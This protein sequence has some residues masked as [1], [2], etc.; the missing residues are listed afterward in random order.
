M[1][2]DEAKEKWCPFSRVLAH[3]YAQDGK[4]RMFEGGYSSNR[5]PDREPEDGSLCIGAACMAWRWSEEK[6][7]AA[8][9]QATVEHMKA[10]GDNF[11]KATQEVVKRRD[12]F[13]HTEGFCGL[14]GA[15]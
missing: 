9:L 4:G 14:A 2:E 12:E 1:T 11:N 10:T 5:G 6:R 3:T 13:K 15:L 8:F 7:T